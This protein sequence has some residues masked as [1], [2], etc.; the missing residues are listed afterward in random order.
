[1]CR[2]QNDGLRLPRH[3]LTTARSGPSS[4]CIVTI[5]N[6]AITLQIIYHGV[7]GA[8]S[9]S[10]AGRSKEAA[11]RRGKVLAMGVGM[12]VVGGSL[13]S[14]RIIPAGT[15]TSWPRPVTTTRQQI[16]QS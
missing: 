10:T 4:T 14:E 16:A 13:F 5:Q 12:A 3:Q 11:S 8:G 15:S 6:V 2:N 7:G 9:I 1:M